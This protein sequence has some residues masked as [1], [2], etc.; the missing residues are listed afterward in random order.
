MK[1]KNLLTIIV[2]VAAF[3]ACNKEQNLSELPANIKTDLNF[4]KLETVEVTYN[5][6]TIRVQHNGT[7][8]DT[9][10][11][12][13]TDKPGTKD[14]ILIADKLAELTANG[15][16]K[17]LD[18]RTNAR[19]E[20][21]NL[22]PGKKYKYIVFAVTADGMLY[23]KTASVIFETQESEFLLSTCND[24]TVTYNG[25]DKSTNKESYSI[26]FSAGA[27]RCHVG[28]IPKWL[29]DYYESDEELQ[30]TIEEFGGIIGT[31]GEYEFL[32][33][34]MDMLVW[35]EL[36]EYW[37]YYDGD[38]GY[39]LQE[40]FGESYTFS[41]P[42]QESGDYY[43]VAIGFEDCQPT[44]TYSISEVTITPETATEDYN[45]WIGDWTI[46][47]SNNITYTLNLEASDPNFSYILRGWE[48]GRVHESTCENTCTEHDVYTD[49][50]EWGNAFPCYFNALNG[51]L[52]IKSTMIGLVEDIAWGIYGFDKLEEGLMAI[53]EEEELI[54]TAAITEGGS[55]ELV[56]ASSVRY[57]ESS[58]VTGY[59]E[60][61]FTYSSL[62][63]A[64]YNTNYEVDGWNI[65]MELPATLTRVESEPAAPAARNCDVEA[66]R[67]EMVANSIKASKSRDYSKL[68]LTPS[69]ISKRIR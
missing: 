69:M 22:E 17:G 45:K 6:A 14:A 37:G 2:A 47:S 52:Q 56:G 55:T 41:I 33:S 3:C 29:V 9:W 26:E 34:I 23:G 31:I 19:I 43:A 7:A 49:F 44:L 21:K 42:R 51:E 10:I 32:F 12:F 35:E 58:S 27:G 60:I 18:K 68:Q 62:G 50:T 67:K 16:I 64:M 40:T 46:T 25:R 57:E 63:Y 54:A 5:S 59:D 48:C 65:P 15:A 8:S 39:F 11:G 66:A 30:Q 1:I 53:I 20:V 61:P 38:E 36:Y 4:T 24:W 13:V 28:F